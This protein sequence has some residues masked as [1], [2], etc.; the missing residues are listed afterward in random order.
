[1]KGRAG[2]SLFEVLIAFVVLSLVLAALI[3]GQS[4]LLT[5]ATLQDQ[6][7]LAHDY[8]LSRIAPLGI[9]GDLLPGTTQDRYR[10]WFVQVD[11]VPGDTIGASTQ[12][13]QIMVTVRDLQ[14]RQLARVETFRVIP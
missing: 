6:R 4:A 8:A 7:A 10:D 2:Y 9:T 14:D 12:T 1:M 3:P 11:V 5:R 13:Q